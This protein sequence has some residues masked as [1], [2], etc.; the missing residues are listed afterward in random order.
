MFIPERNRV[1]YVSFCSL[2]WT[3]LLSYVKSLETSQ[4]N[5]GSVLM[6]E[7]QVLVPA[8][9][10]DTKNNNNDNNN[11]SKNQTTESTQKKPTS[12]S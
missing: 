3:S 8:A 10:T 6:K 4:L 1:V 2:G 12:L 5:N 7:P 9:N 11:S